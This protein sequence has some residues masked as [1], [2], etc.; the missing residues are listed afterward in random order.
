MA[1]QGAIHSPFRLIR[2]GFHTEHVSTLFSI[3]HEKKGREA[4][5]KP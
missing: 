5:K 3:F 1:A 2:F 4:G